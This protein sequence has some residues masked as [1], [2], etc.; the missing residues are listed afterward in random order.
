MGDVRMTPPSVRRPE[1]IEGP[2]K[3]LRM[4]HAAY[5]IDLLLGSIWPGKSYSELEH[6]AS[7]SSE[8][9]R[10]P[11]MVISTIPNA[12]NMSQWVKNP[13]LSH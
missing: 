2:T 4:N 7:V 11:S 13:N 12:N 3:I 5:D 10:C 9:P 6:R 1:K 8:L